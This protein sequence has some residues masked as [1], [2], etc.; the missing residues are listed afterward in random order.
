MASLQCNPQDRHGGQIK[1]QSAN[2]VTSTVIS[3]VYSKVSSYG[4]FM[5]LNDL[6]LGFSK[7][8]YL[9]RFIKM[10]TQGELL[11]LHQFLPEGAPKPKIHN[12]KFRPAE[13]SEQ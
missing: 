3:V 10:A 8:P 1:A 11:K 12:T 7:R 4:Y 2:R 9:Q 6:S 13:N 5:T